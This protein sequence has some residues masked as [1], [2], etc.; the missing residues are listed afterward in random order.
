MNKHKLDT[1]K[2][3]DLHHQEGEVSV[4]PG[5]PSPTLSGSPVVDYDGRTLRR[6]QQATGNVRMLCNPD[7]DSTSDN[8][9]LFNYD[10]GCYAAFC[11]HITMSGRIFYSFV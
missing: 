1:A 7:E 10:Y 2:F 6:D 11:T 3:T 4:S 5:S 9:W 8:G